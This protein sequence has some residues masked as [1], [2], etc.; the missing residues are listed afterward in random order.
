MGVGRHLPDH[1]VNGPGSLVGYAVLV[2]VVGAVVALGRR[3]PPVIAGIALMATAALFPAV[4]YRY[5]LVFVLPVAALVVRDPDGRPGSGIFDRFAALGDRHRAVGVCVSLSAA[6]SIAQIALPRPHWEVLIH[7]QMGVT[8][9]I[10]TTTLVFTTSLLAPLAWLITCAVIIVSYARRPV[11]SQVEVTD[12]LDRTVPP[13]G[14][15]TTSRV[16]R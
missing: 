9:V 8:G 4:S 15:A 11:P 7:G 12:G 13:D 3:T 5:Y 2:L 1:F 10:G 16:S 6:L 14:A